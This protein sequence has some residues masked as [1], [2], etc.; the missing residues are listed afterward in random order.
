MKMLA[1]MAR[2]L[3]GWDVGC[4]LVRISRD[5]GFSRCRLLFEIVS[6]SV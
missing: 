4:G 1:G 6:T 3:S 5:V 2:A